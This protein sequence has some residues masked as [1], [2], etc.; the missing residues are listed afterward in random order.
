MPAEPQQ[1]ACSAGSARS[2]PGIESSSSRGSTRIPCA[3]ARWHESWKATR[4]SSGCR[5]ALG[6]SASSSETSTTRTSSP[7]SFR[8]DPQPAALTAIASTPAKRSATARAIRFPF[9]PPTG[10]EM[11]RAAACLARRRDDLVALRGQHAS[12]RDVDVAEDDALYA[13]GEQAD[14]PSPLYSSLL[15]KHVAL[16]AVPSS[17]RAAPARPATAATS[18]RHARRR[19]DGERNPQPAADAG[20]PRRRATAEASRRPAARTAPRRPRASA[21][22]AGRSGRPTG[23]RSR[24]PCSRGSGRCARRPSELAVIVPS[25]SPFMS[26]IRPRGESASI[27]PS[28]PYVGHVGRQKPQCVQASMSSR[29]ITACP[30]AQSTGLAGR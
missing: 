1:I 24:T 15:R 12:R 19:G 22:S 11:K 18:A 25:A 20:T 8:C 7:A 23:T 5:S 27:W 29:S 2:R 17:A 14:S 30:G 4:S 28:G 9:L 13:A 26:Q 21:R 16:A 6:S 3:W 10:M